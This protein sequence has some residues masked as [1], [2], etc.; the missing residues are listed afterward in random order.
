MF[1]KILGTIRIPRPPSLAILALYAAL[2]LGAG[3]VGGAG[4]LI[5]IRTMPTPQ[6]C[7]SAINTADKLHIELTNLLSVVRVRGDALGAEAYAAADADVNSVLDAVEP[8]DE[9][10]TVAALE[11]TGGAR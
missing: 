8:L 3:V 6:A 2:V 1:R 7:T 5:G 9:A 11:C 10:Y 4:Y